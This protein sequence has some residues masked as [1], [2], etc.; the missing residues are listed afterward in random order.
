MGTWTPK[1]PC[2]KD[3]T[4]IGQRLS[5][6]GFQVRIYNFAQS[7]ITVE[8]ESSLHVIASIHRDGI[9]LDLKPVDLCFLVALHARASQS[10]LTCFEEEVLLD[11]FEQVCDVVDPDGENPR[12]RATSAIQRL[13]EQR[14]LSR[15]DGDGMVRAGDYSMTRLA[16]SIVEFFMEDQVLTRQSLSLLTKTLLASLAQVKTEAKKTQTVEE[17]RQAVV[18]PLRVTVS[19]LIDGIDRRQ[20]GLDVQ[21]EQVR[22]QIRDLLEADWF[23]AVDRCQ[24]LLDDTTTTLADLNSVLLHDT[25]QILSALSDIEQVAT[26]AGISEAEEATQRVYEQVERV[27]VWGRTRQQAWS[28]YYQ[29]VHRYLRD[30]VRLDPSRA[31]SERLRNQLA[32]WTKRPFY[33]VVAQASKIRVLRENEVREQRPPVTRPPQDREAPLEYVPS[34]S[35]ATTLEELVRAAVANGKVSLSDVLNVVLPQVDVAKRFVAIGRIAAL[36]AS[37]VTVRS[38]RDRP[39]VKV[40]GEIEVEDWVL[41]GEYTHA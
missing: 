9:G 29:Y 31:L 38:D 3:T 40:P 32:D 23:A 41:V 13:R 5:Y 33:W 36:V 12:K 34:D 11:V 14:L 7:E 27:A 19:D 1:Y 26:Q 25:H 10:S 15:V 24:Q 28:T 18:G 39:W 6:G 2:R 21:Q 35:E 8:R 16:L 22:V 20:R 30:V 17:W 4:L 37:E